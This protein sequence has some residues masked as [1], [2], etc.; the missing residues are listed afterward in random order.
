V[1]LLPVRE[2]K[3]IRASSLGGFDYVIPAGAEQVDGAFK[4]I[5]F[6]SAPEFLDVAWPAGRLIPVTTFDPQDP[7]WPEAYAVYRE[8][9][10]SA[11]ARGPHPR[12]PEISRP[13]AN[14]LQE[15]LT[16]AKTPAEALQGA[17]DAIAPILAEQPL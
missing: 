10:E 9:L 16:G 14:A 8:Q 12:W 3:D 4:F 7:M 1:A 11:R 13:I 2:G 17:A 5:E 6:V 15:A